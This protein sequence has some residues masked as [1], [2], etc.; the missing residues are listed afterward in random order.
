LSALPSRG[1]LCGPKLWRRLEPQ[2]KLNGLRPNAL[3]SLT[4]SSSAGKEEKSA[5]LLEGM[6][7]ST[8]E[9]VRLF[10]KT[11]HETIKFDESPLIRRAEASEASSYPYKDEI[12]TD[13]FPSPDLSSMGVVFMVEANKSKFIVV[14]KS[15]PQADMKHFGPEI[16]WIELMESTG[17]QR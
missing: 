2:A 12:E 16:S 8:S 10:W 7:I 3:L 13:E 9:E 1:L 5:T 6:P 15:R 4:Y 11:L 14:V 17:K